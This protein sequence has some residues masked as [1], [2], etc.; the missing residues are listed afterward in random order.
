MK[1]K[2]KEE[3][4]RGKKKVEKKEKNELKKKLIPENTDVFA[5]L[6]NSGSC[7][8]AVP[9]ISAETFHDR[10]RTLLQIVRANISESSVMPFVM[11]MKRNKER[12][13]KG[14]EKNT[15]QKKEGMTGEKEKK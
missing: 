15:K 7:R 6:V 9:L 10:V 1:K 14:G 11:R 2:E 13:E 8:E 5:K 3:K 4:G 12:R